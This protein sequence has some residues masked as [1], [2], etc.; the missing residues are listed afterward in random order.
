[1]S[2]EQ[3][4]KIDRVLL[5]IMSVVAVVGWALVLFIGVIATEDCKKSCL[6]YIEGGCPSICLYVNDTTPQIDIN[7]LRGFQYGKEQRNNTNT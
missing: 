3:E 6:E 2:S 5:Y 4:A 7:E 1:V